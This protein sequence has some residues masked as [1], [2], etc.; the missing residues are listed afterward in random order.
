MYPSIAISVGK[1]EQHEEGE[2]SV[3][4]TLEREGDFVL[5]KRR[6]YVPVFARFYPREKEEGWW[7]VVGDPQSNVLIDIKRISISRETENVMM[8]C[9][10]NERPKIYLMSDS[11][12]GCD[13]E[14]D[15][16]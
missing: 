13:Q 3:N 10:S 7:L 14:E 5:D 4:V 9:G 1:I 8:R 12:I 11:F 15:I 2:L 16:V 6:I